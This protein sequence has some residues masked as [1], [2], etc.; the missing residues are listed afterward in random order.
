MNMI[1]RFAS[2][3]CFALF[4][5]VAISAQKFDPQY[6][7]EDIKTI[8]G[9]WFMPT[10]RGDRLEIWEIVD[11]STMT[12]RA[13][14]IKQEDGDTVLLEALKLT[15]RDTNIVYTVVVRGQNAN[16]P[17][18]F[19]LIEAYR[20][21]FVFANPRHDDPQII[22]YVLLGNREMQVTTEGK[23]NNRTVTHEFVFEREFSKSATQFRIRAGLGAGS[24]V[25]ERDFTG[26]FEQKPA[27][28]LRP[29]WEVAIG[30]AFK[31]AGGFLAMNMEVGIAGKYSGVDARFYLDTIYVRN[32]SYRMTWLTAAVFPEFTLR[33]EG[34]LSA[35]VGPYYGRLL[36]NTP[37]GDFSPANRNKSFNSNTDLNKNDF[38]I[39]AGLQY[40]LKIGKK[41]LDGKI[42]A[43]VNLGL[44]NL[45]N[46]YL[47]RCT[48]S[49]NTCN[50][51]VL[52]R[53]VS[54][55]Y[56]VDLAKL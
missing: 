33:R 2:A 50:E 25:K 24:L 44:T 7:F 26:N 41:D 36:V 4:L 54:V 46:L 31:G 43:R 37:N 45:D 17:I 27:F 23:K 55:Y 1:H 38:G 14:R 42:G 5:P 47:R 30:T 21:E 15:L 34:R 13:L 39:L 9:V 16:K 18:E 51:R 49:T 20:D 3:I 28:A 32:G 22:R 6:A 53:S 11:D 29:S 48:S 35:I 52:L 10:D 19:K 40:K 12:G 56:T 8:K